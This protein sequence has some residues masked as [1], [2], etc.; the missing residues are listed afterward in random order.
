MLPALLRHLPEMIELAMQEKAPQMY[1]RLKASGDL[2]AEIGERLAVALESFR[3]VS[4]MERKD[5][6]LARQKLP[7][8][9]QV[10]ARTMQLKAAAEEAIAQAIEFPS[11]S[12][13]EK[14]KPDSTPP[15]GSAPETKESSMAQL[16]R[17]VA[18][19]GK[20]TAIRVPP[21]K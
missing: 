4:S 20:I 16:A 18:M 13:M 11:E 21:K 5:A 19:G 15:S 7:P 1:A 17:L 6:V 8:M 14:Q 9:D 3:E 10:Q 12:E 2:E